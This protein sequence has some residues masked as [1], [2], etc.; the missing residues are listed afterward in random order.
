MKTTDLLVV[1]GGPA[2]LATALG[3]RRHGLK[4]T[5]ADPARPPIDKA[6]GEGLMPDA[7][8]ALR[9]L[10]VD[11]PFNA[12][13]PFR[14]IRF[15]GYGSQVEAQFPDGTGLGIRRT[16][17][18]EILVRSAEDAGVE[19]LWGRQVIGIEQDRAWAGGERIAFANLAGADGGNSQVRRWAGLDERSR[20]GMR[21]GFRRHYRI[22]PWSDSVE[23]HWAPGGQIYVTPIAQDCVCIALLVRRQNLRL[24]EALRLFPA[25]EKRLNGAAA[26]APDRGGTSAFRRLRRVVSGN[27]ALVG[28][29]SGSVD[30]VTGEG[31]SLA[32]RQA[33]ALTEAIACGRLEQY[34]QAHERI[35]QGPDRMTSL[36]LMMD[37]SDA[38]CHR[39]LKALACKPHI[40]S[41]MLAAHVGECSPAALAVALCS[42]SWSFLTA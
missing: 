10:G 5:V 17:L 28:D 13:A 29:A 37:R 1:G 18:H 39:S 12:G 25:V 8:A 42:L 30:A 36:L 33:A 24:D 32:F 9:E 16:R 38:L 34:Q 4:V 27:I 22:R 3:A 23:V 41:S 31:M 26:I 11:L 19:F 14:G 21:F 35:R 15:L 6:C 40:F 20:E 2:G 7:L